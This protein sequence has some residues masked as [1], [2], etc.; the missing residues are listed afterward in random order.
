MNILLRLCTSIFC[1]G[2]S[3]AMAQSS[4]DQ[5]S[6]VSPL[7]TFGDFRTVAFGNDGYVALGGSGLIAASMDGVDW[8]T[9]PRES[10]NAYNQV[11]FVDNQFVA[12]GSAS[13]NG[14]KGA[15]TS[16][17][18]VLFSPQATG[19]LN[20]VN[21]ILYV[22]GRFVIVGNTGG[23]AVSDD[24]VDWRFVG[25]SGEFGHFYGIAFGNDVFV[26]VGDRGLTATSP[27][28]VADFV[29]VGLGIFEA[30]YDVAFG[31]GNFVASG[32]AGKIYTSVDGV[33]WEER[34]SGVTRALRRLHFADGRFV[35]AGDDGVIVSSPN[36]IEWSVHE[37]GTERDLMGITRANGLWTVVGENGTILQSPDLSQ[38]E[39]RF[40]GISHELNGVAYHGGTI[41]AFGRDQMSQSVDGRTW[42]SFELGFEPERHDFER[43]YLIGDE[44]FILSSRFLARSQDL[45]DW[46]EIGY[47]GVNALD[48][49]FGNDVFVLVGDSGLVRTSADGEDWQFEPGLSG[50]LNAVVFAQGQFVAV[51]DEAMIH[52]SLDGVEWQSVPSPSPD[53]RLTSIVYGNGVFLATTSARDG[54]LIRSRDAMAWTAVDLAELGLEGVGR[55]NKVQFL[56]N[57]FVALESGGRIVSSAD[58]LEWILHDT[59]VT[60]S[61][62]DIVSAEGRNVLVGVDGLVMLS[63]A[64]NAPVLTIETDRID[65]GAF[66]NQ[67][68]PPDS[69]MIANAGQGVLEF[70]VEVSVPWVSVDVA[71][72]GVGAGQSIAATLN[73]DPSGLRAGL[74]EGIVSVI[75]ANGLSHEIIVSLSLKTPEEVLLGSRFPIDTA[76]V[77]HPGF[78]TGSLAV[79]YVYRIQ[80]LEVT[81]NEYAAFLNAVTEG[82]EDPLHLYNPEMRIRWDGE[83]YLPFAGEFNTPVTYVSLFDAMRFV[84]WVNNGMENGNTEVGAY[85]LIGNKP[86]PDDAHAIERNV[87]ISWALPSYAE[88][89]KA[90]YVRNDESRIREVWSYATSSDSAPIAEAPPGGGNSA[91][92]NGAV[93]RLT[94]V[95]AYA[96]AESP[97]YA[98]DMNGNV[99]EYT[100]TISNVDETQDPPVAARILQGGHFKTGPLTGPL[101]SG[102]HEL[103]RDPSEENEVTGFRLVRLTDVVR[104]ADQR[105]FVTEFGGGERTEFHYYIGANGVFVRHGPLREFDSD[106][107]LVGTGQYEHGRRAG[108]WEAYSYFNGDRKTSIEAFYTLDN[109]GLEIP[110]NGTISNLLRDSVFGYSDDGMALLREEHRYYVPIEEAGTLLKRTYFPDGTPETAL[111]VD[112]PLGVGVVT[113][114]WPNGRIRQT[115][116]VI[117]REP[118]WV[119]YGNSGRSETFLESGE[120]SKVEHFDESGR[121]HGLSQEFRS[122]G[123]LLAATEWRQ[124]M[125]NGLHREWFDSEKIKLKATYKDGELDGH[126]QVYELQIDFET[127]DELFHGLREESWHR[128][129]VILREKEYANSPIWPAD[130]NPTQLDDTE[131]IDGR[132]ANR[133]VERFNLRDEQREIS[134]RQRFAL[135]E[136]LGELRLHGLSEIYRFDPDLGVHYLSSQSNYHFGFLEGE[137]LRYHSNGNLLSSQLYENGELH[138]LSRFFRS[139]GSP[140]HEALYSKGIRNGVRRV[141]FE[142]GL[143]EGAFG[144]PSLVES[145][146]DD[147]LHGK[148]THFYP[149][150]Q[151]REQTRFFRGLENG[152]RSTF[153]EDGTLRT[154]ARIV[155]GVECGSRT[156]LVSGSDSEGDAM[157]ESTIL[158]ECVPREP[159]PEAGEYGE[160]E[161]AFVE[162]RGTI[163][164]ARTGLPVEGVRIDGFPDAG[165][166][167]TDAKGFYIAVIDATD[168]VELEL[169]RERFL[170]VEATVRLEDT[171]SKTQNF[172]MVK[173]LGQEPAIVSFESQYG[174]IFIEGISVRNEIQTSV[175]WD[176][177]DP[178]AILYNLNGQE[179]SVAAM[180]EDYVRVYDM[181]RDFIPS[182]RPG[183]N[184]LS[185]SARNGDLQFSP[186]EVFEPIVV[187][188]PTWSRSLGERF[189][190]QLDDNG[191]WRYDI[192]A[193]FPSKPFDFLLSQEN[194]GSTVWSVWD[195]IPYLGGMELGV[196]QTQ[197]RVAASVLSDGTGTVSVSGQTG[198]VGAGTTAVGMLGGGGDLVYEPGEGI[199][200][201]GTSLSF[202]IDVE[203]AR[204][205][206]IVTVFPPLRAAEKV[207]V[208]GKLVKWFNKRARVRASIENSA[209]VDMNL[210]HENGSVVFE[211]AEG[212]I[213]A[214]LGLGLTISAHEDLTVD[215]DGS[216]GAEV[217]FQLPANPDYL[218][219]VSFELAGAVTLTAWNYQSEIGGSHTFEFLDD[220]SPALLSGPR[221]RLQDS[222]SSLGEIVMRPMS[223]DFLSPVSHSVAVARPLIRRR[224]MVPSKF[225]VENVYPRSNPVI[226]ARDGKRAIAYVGFDAKDSALQGTEIVFSYDGGNGFSVPAPIVD[227]TRSEFTPTLAMANDGKVVAV[228]ERVKAADFSDGS[229]DGLL[230]MAANMEV[231]YASFD[232]VMSSWSEVVSLSNNDYLD[233]APALVSDG[234]GR[235]RLFWLSNE[236]NELW[237]DADNP[238][239]IHTAEWGD[240]AFGEI[241][242][243]PF[244]FR[245]AAGFNYA[246]QGDELLIAYSHDQ[247]GDLETSI[248]QDLFVTRFDGDVWSDPSN[249]TNSPDVADVKPT[250][251]YDSEGS[252]RLF[253]M[254]DSQLV[255]TVGL[256]PDLARVTRDA[257]GSAAF[258]DYQIFADD[259]G[260]LFLLWQGREEGQID[261]SFTVYD[262]ATKTWSQ[263]LRLTD[264]KTAETQAHAVFSS[265]GTLDLVFNEILD[266]D[267]SHVLLRHLEY[268]LGR[269]LAIAPEG[270]EIVPPDFGPGDAVEVRVEV[271]NIGDLTLVEPEVGLYLGNPAAGGASIESMRLEAPLL[272]GTSRIV[273]FDWIAPEAFTEDSLFAWADPRGE[274][275]EKTE[276]NNTQSIVFLKP[277][278]VALSLRAETRPDG[279]LDLV[280][281]FANEG[282]GSAESFEVAFLSGEERLGEVFVPIVQ[283]GKIAEVSLASTVNALTP[284]VSAIDMVVDPDQ[285]LFEIRSDNN[286]T[287][288]IRPPDG[289]V[290]GDEL[291]DWWEQRLIDL[292]DSDEFD[293]LSS[294]ASNGDFD[295]DGQSNWVEFRTGT[296]A[297]DRNSVFGIAAFSRPDGE[298]RVSISFQSQPGEAYLIQYSFDLETWF[299]SGAPIIAESETSDVT[300]D[301]GEDRFEMPRLFLR[302]RLR[303]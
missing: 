235:I 204:E 66:V 277:D 265:N 184:R 224:A 37:S 7:P 278:L 108:K 31:A 43:F 296:D 72:D 254:K 198:L 202:G 134:G 59:G 164:D 268:D 98:H 159:D 257:S 16:N 143:V 122:D 79:D 70:D 228:W 114:W 200:W 271:S 1:V 292:S 267:R 144:V 185:V 73:Y 256:N 22:D 126:R 145:F 282:P 149:N 67:P 247:D 65:A 222:G 229:E 69:F 93:G 32:A 128:D 249:I 100:E 183:V 161:E 146:R 169:S 147:L 153:L 8:E 194:V 262:P 137:S 177:A 273:T 165:V 95:G 212:T 259:A 86:V 91:N 17:D 246:H 280:A 20:T 299:N 260:C 197:A 130:Q 38:W 133:T 80:K 102:V 57:R 141:F 74:Y 113:E 203:T 148:Q 201:K 36:G 252:L 83:R 40:R 46:E 206:S 219:R 291:P 234:A 92:W 29:G 253:W 50:D 180:G 232:P 60:N 119:S 4:L 255:E 303:E 30:L 244:E 283:A 302:V 110:E 77:G 61:L 33:E 288:A 84:N 195:K 263:D 163:T 44:Y 52:T 139:D 172:Q 63:V 51:S 270:I 272:A 274:F 239:R 3:S 300:I 243:H 223:T 175:Y 171:L 45:I 27:D 207:K 48:L 140:D 82:G 135:D 160:F 151:A 156:V 220:G 58:G 124:G 208:I 238:A 15:F 214:G 174:N 258:L 18:G 109:L 215:L 269:D 2:F 242:T 157:Y 106:N 125:R 226:A 251:L 266:G 132:I 41:F 248:D 297:A 275:P 96:S 19:L 115:R 94:P 227:D 28:A 199:A 205:E 68:V 14:Q 289:D 117:E 176:I 87:G 182:F 136:A 35:A 120:L 64:D 118:V 71:I 188:V 192:A 237:N 218:K 231:V 49:A 245:D 62:T 276:A 190:P 78:P 211:E 230:A 104:E 181:G 298:G 121:R 158:R 173:I 90:A 167:L 99:R 216:G 210:I 25:S 152:V 250:V 213:G 209:A 236:G 225:L 6:L 293:S 187:P 241:R 240:G 179:T 34:N 39:N 101:D 189:Q 127:G 13:F 116:E 281:R 170:P 150:G 162:I 287:F 111:V 76:R 23:L 131:F 221:S 9:V 103:S 284:G 42:T 123:V 186:A 88:W 217:A 5:W 112:G 286:S 154:Q 155:D 285:R 279:A 168:V 196:T 26:A 261:L 24:G 233:H 54:Q 53:E 85:T 193:F 142:P 81:N 97:W 21:D 12:V 56:S 166:T 89:Y 55:L 11:I 129:G 105:L 47:R 301:L 191:L 264:S 294:V 107:R 138:G 178:D 75:A 295:G 290:D 10:F